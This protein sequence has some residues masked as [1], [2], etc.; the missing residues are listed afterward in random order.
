[1]TALLDSLAGFS[2]IC[3]FSWANQDYPKQTELFG[4]LDL[5]LFGFPPLSLAVQLS[6]IHF[7]NSLRFHLI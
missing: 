5:L 3:S 6:H 2:G 4:F 7:L 1:M